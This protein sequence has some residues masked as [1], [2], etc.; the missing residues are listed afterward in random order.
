MF[1][2]IV[3]DDGSVDDSFEWI[4]KAA[5]EFER[6]R[7]SRNPS[8][9]GKSRTLLRALHQSD[10]DLVITIDSDTVFA[11]ETI[12]ELVACFADP[13][14]GGVGGRVGVENVNTNALTV[15]QTLVYY[16]QYQLS[17]LAESWTRTVTCIPG[18]LFA[19]RR[20]LL[21]RIEPKIEARNWCGLRVNDGEDRYMTHMLLLQGCGTVLNNDARCWTTV[22][23]SFSQLFKQQTRWRRGSLRDFFMTLR[24][25]PLNI[26]SVHPAGIFNMVIPPLGVLAAAVVIFTSPF[27]GVAFQQVPMVLA[28]YSAA[29]LILALIIRRHSPEQRIFNPLA[30]AAF[31]FWFMVSGFITILA[32]FTFDTTD[33]GTRAKSRLASSSKPTSD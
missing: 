9:L 12:L 3:V 23:S 8:N 6:V 18:C 19:I 7:P 21:L 30:F 32:L 2:V 14:I 11:P 10:A 17:K 13:K 22:P 15:A 27:R 4:L 25:L 1:E 26:A 31:T 16:V 5:S 29:G 28:G 20:E 24:T 33:W